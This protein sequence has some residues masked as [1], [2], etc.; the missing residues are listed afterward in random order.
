MLDKVEMFL[1]KDKDGNIY[2]PNNLYDIKRI[3]KLIIPAA[4]EKY[5]VTRYRALNSIYEAFN[6]KTPEQIREIKIE[7]FKKQFEKNF[8]GSYYGSTTPKKEEVEEYVKD[9]LK[10]LTFRNVTLSRVEKWALKK[11]PIT[12][13]KMT[14]VIQ[15]IEECPEVLI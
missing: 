4:N 1:F 13:V 5:A 9:R 3:K 10:R 14:A 2:N 8:I 15:K 6:G 11:C 12:I 7:E